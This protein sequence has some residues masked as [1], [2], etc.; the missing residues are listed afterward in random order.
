MQTDLFL[1]GRYIHWQGSISQ[2][3]ACSASGQ[4]HLEQYLTGKAYAVELATLQQALA[5]GS[6]C[7]GIRVEQAFAG[8]SE[9]DD[10]SYSQDEPALAQSDTVIT[11]LPTFNVESFFTTSQPSFK[12]RQRF[13][14]SRKSRPAFKAK[15]GALA[16]DHHSSEA[17]P[18]GEQALSTHTSTAKTGAWETDQ[19]HPSAKALKRALQGP[20]KITIRW[21]NGRQTNLLNFFSP[22]PLAEEKTYHPL[23]TFHHEAD[24]RTYDSAILASL[25]FKKPIYILIIDEW[26]HMIIGG[27]IAFKHI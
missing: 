8:A 5:K 12:K 14:R 2:I 25:G 16:R 10:E 24:Q 21:I 19:E 3:T 9:Q 4:I 15:R 20:G 22:E 6:L 1:V 27:Y 18:E 13:V 7:I 23:G 26:S 11:Y 17:P